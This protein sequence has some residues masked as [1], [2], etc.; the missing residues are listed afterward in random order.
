ME[1]QDGLPFLIF[2][3]GATLLVALLIKAGLR[4]TGI[5]VLVG[6]LLLGFLLRVFDEQWTLLSEEAWTTFEFLG[7]LGVIA[8]LF[9]VGLE[10]NVGR[11]ASQLSRA[12]VIWIGNILGSGF[13]GY[14]VASY[15]LD[16]DVITSVIIGTALTATS[17]GVAVVP[18]QEVHALDSPTGELLIDVAELDDISAIVL[19]ALLFAILPVY[20]EANA[21]TNLF[22]VLA[23]KTAWLLISLF[24]FGACCFVFAKY[25][26]N[27]VT[28]F[29]RDIECS[30]SPMLLV[31]TTS[32]IIAASS[33]ILGFSVAIGA[34]FAGLVFS[35]DPQSV[36]IDASF[37]PLYNLFTPFFFISI[38]LYVDPGALTAVL[39]VGMALLLAAILGKIIGTSGSALMVTDGKSSVLLGVSMVPRAEIAMLIMLQG[40][41]LGNWAVSSEVF[42]AMT[43][44]SIVS[45][46]ASPFVLQPLLQRWP[47]TRARG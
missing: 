9:R 30:S 41:Q 7:S 6:Y 46:V 18:W 16:F 36:K 28:R 42:A 32:I 43:F 12:S 13:L 3:V 21:P 15:V 26:E 4:Y 38:G 5:P 39:D 8:L 14:V 34:F 45:C 24:G 20:G 25:A 22:P 2:L 11:L 1:I 27:V 35:R 47:Q 31:V 23:E 17:V 37:E 33:G 44:V 10:S 29:F 40:H 19:M